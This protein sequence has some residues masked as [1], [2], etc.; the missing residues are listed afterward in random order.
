[1]KHLENKKD[2]DL[3]AMRQELEIPCVPEAVDRKLR[4]V[5]AELP[6]ELPAR[7]Q[8]GR[9]AVKGLLYSASAVAAAFLMLFGV[10]AMNP[11]FAEELPLI[12]NLFTLMNTHTMTPMG[13]NVG[14]YQENVQKVG[15]AAT[16]KQDTGYGLTV[17][18]A[19]CDGKYIYATLSLSVPKEGEQYGH[20][21][22]K[23]NGEGDYR[24]LI[25]GKEAKEVNLTS[26]RRQGGSAI[27]VV[28][29][30]PAWVKDGETFTVSLEANRLYGVDEDY[31]TNGKYEPI[32]AA[33]T[34]DFPV[35]VDLSKNT[36][37][38]V[39]AM[40]NGVK[41]YSVE[42]TPGYFKVDMEMPVWGTNNELVGSYGGG[43]VGYVRLFTED[44]QEIRHNS[45]LNQ[46]P[47]GLEAMDQETVRGI[48]GFEGPAE[49]DEKVVLRIDELSPGSV[50]P[51]LG[52]EEP[53]VFA[54]FTIDCK[55]GTAAPSEN[56][57]QEGLKKIDTQEYQTMEKFPDYTGGY[58]VQD[59]YIGID[60][61]YT[62]ETDHGLYEVG[63]LAGMEEY[64][65]L[66]VRF[67]QDGE[68]AAT[69]KSHPESEYN[70]TVSS[71]GGPRCYR[72]E[73]GMYTAYD[74]EFPEDCDGKQ[75]LRF[76]WH[77]PVEL[78]K[79]YTR[80]TDVFVQIADSQ[81]G[82]VLLDRAQMGD[83]CK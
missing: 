53:Y 21:S 42:R 18:E 27:A 2:F 68:L 77:C 83:I 15:V 1:M 59:L 35:T 52:R 73:T 29:E 41:L 33:F 64:R 22:L 24:F 70:D 67:F 49:Q 10:N 32:E 82:E 62:G 30:A 75:V 4:Q 76:A 44:G 11:A 17:D 9:R 16:A 34:V 40:D 20:V 51:G 36:N 63:L 38:D 14:T 79:N 48:W 50:Y 12:G 60:D 54:E 56:Y 61:M 5:Y 19:F 23:C 66:E 43:I 25:D 74:T 58:L 7:R 65:P 81:T 55:N 6:E 26:D 69:V 47:D 37:A 45:D 78:A 28:L 31:N 13:G 39:Q 3:E 71:E 80:D 8:G 57:L 46:Y 72:D